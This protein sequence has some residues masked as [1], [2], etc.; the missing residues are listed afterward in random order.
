MQRVILLMEWSNFWVVFFLLFFFLTDVI[1]RPKNEN[2]GHRSI[3]NLFFMLCPAA[4]ATSVMIP[5]Q[6][7][8]EQCGTP[9]KA[10]KNNPSR[11]TYCRGAVCKQPLT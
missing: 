2:K 7:M 4:R 6:L 9:C 10:T 5:N 3:I 1:C 8:G 11:T